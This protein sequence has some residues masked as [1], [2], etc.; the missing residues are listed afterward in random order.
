MPAP[1]SDIEICTCSDSC[2]DATLRTSGNFSLV[3]IETGS[4]VIYDSP[5][6]II[7]LSDNKL[8]INTESIER[9]IYPGLNGISFHNFEKEFS[10]KG[11]EIQA[12]YMLINPPY[13]V[14]EATANQIAPVFA[15]G[16][17][18]HFAGDE[19]IWPE[20]QAADDWVGNN[21]SPILGGALQNIWH[22]L[23]TADNTSHIDLK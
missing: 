20:E 17:L 10:V 22:D 4:P 8:Y 16:M 19:T 9:I 21:V 23:P 18:A 3:D 6:R 13:Y 15:Q 11:F 1:L 2:N 14:D 7:N 5:Y 12:K